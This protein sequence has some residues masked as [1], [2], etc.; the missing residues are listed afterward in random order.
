ML[1]KRL[2]KKIIPRKYTRQQLIDYKRDRLA[3]VREKYKLGRKVLLTEYYFGMKPGLVGW[4]VR[5]EPNTNILFENGMCSTVPPEF[6]KL[7]KAF[8]EYAKDIKH[9]EDVILSRKNK[10]KR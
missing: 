10:R 6:C 3:V 7:V 2:M 5:T 8:D 1:K 9:V 4:V